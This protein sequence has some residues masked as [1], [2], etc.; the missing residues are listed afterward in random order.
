MWVHP[1]GNKQECIS[2]KDCTY[3]YPAFMN[4]DKTCDGLTRRQ[5]RVC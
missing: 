1:K 3:M 2:K 5:C 4:P